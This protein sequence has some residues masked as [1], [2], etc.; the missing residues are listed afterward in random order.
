MDDALLRIT[1][2][3]PRMGL[4]D[5]M[6]RTGHPLKG[7]PVRHGIHVCRR[8]ICPRFDHPPVNVRATVPPSMV[9]ETSGNKRANVST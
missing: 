5:A 9:N 3:M 2:E 6:T 7:C 8:P 4:G 1:Q